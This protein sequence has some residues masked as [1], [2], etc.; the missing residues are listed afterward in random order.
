MQRSSH[1]RS[2]RLNLRCIA[3]CQARSSPK[4]A[5]LSEMAVQQAV[6]QPVV[7]RTDVVPATEEEAVQAHRGAHLAMAALPGPL[8]GLR[9]GPLE[10]RSQKGVTS[11]KHVATL[12][13]LTECK[14]RASSDL[15]ARAYRACKAAEE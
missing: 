5:V 4:E 9:A 14:L 1:A 11:S 10:E 8:L 15:P 7:L 12:L 3:V 13:L 2:A 6:H